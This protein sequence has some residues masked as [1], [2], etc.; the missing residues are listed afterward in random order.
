MP[1]IHSMIQKYV[2]PSERATSASIVT[3]A[4]FLGALLSNLISP[5]IISQSGWEACFL[6]FAAVPPLIWLPLWA[7]IFKKEGFG[8]GD[9]DISERESFLISSNNIDNIDINKN[10]NGIDMKTKIMLTSIEPE[11][12]VDRNM[13]NIGINM[14]RI[15][16]STDEIFEAVDAKSIE[17]NFRISLQPLK[18]VPLDHEHVQ[19]LTESEILETNNINEVNE[20]KELTL[21]TLLSSPPVWAIIAAQY[22]QSWGMIGLL[23]WLPTYYSQRYNVP[24]ESLSNFTVLPYFLQMLVAV[25]AGFFA[26]KLVQSGVRTLK[27]RQSFQILGML[28]PA[29]CLTYCAYVPSLEANQAAALITFGSAISAMTVAAVSANHFDISPKNAGTIFGLGNTAGCIGKYSTNYI[30]S[31]VYATDIMI[32]QIL[33]LFLS[34]KHTHTHTHTHTISQIHTHTL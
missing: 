33:S 14:N 28:V 22:G 9:S 2:L 26:D 10:S 29:A 21:R 17:E 34:L 23:S 13:K 24:L 25:S 16:V 15:K 8:F 18:V 31:F 11:N 7:L 4:C 1:A 20:D 12:S 5:M 27:V 6:Y 32:L 3:A 30:N 19:V